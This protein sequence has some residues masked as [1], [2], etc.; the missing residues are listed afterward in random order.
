MRRYIFIIVLV[1]GCF[2]MQAQEKYSVVLEKSKQM[3]PY[4]SM[5]LLMDYQAWHP[6][7]A[8]VYYQLGNVCYGLV[9][10]RDPL[11]HYAELHTLLYQ[12]R[13]FYG[14]CLHFGKDQ[15][16]QGWQY[17]EIAKGEKKIEY[18]DLRRYIKPRMDDVK[19]RQIAC[20]SIHSSFNRMVER[21]NHCQALFSSF[22]R[23]YTREKTAHWQLQPEERKM[24]IELQQ[25]ADKLEQD[26]AAFRQAL[27][28]QKIEGYDPVFRKEEIVLYRLDGLTY[29][30]FLQNDI[31]LWDYSKWV[32][33][34]LYE[35]TYVY[36]RLFEDIQREYD[37]LTAQLQRYAE[38]K[39]IAGSIDES[40]MGR[41]AR[42]E[43]QTPRI[44]SIRSMQNLA[45][46]GAAEQLIAKAPAPKSLREMQP[47]LQIAA[48]NYSATLDSAQQ[49][50]ITRLVQMAQPLRIQQQPTYTH[51][52]S[53]D[54]IR[55]TPDDGETVLTLLPD[56]RGYR[57][58]VYSDAQT[59]VLGLN[60]DLEIE[61]IILKLPNEKP[62]VYA[63]LSSDKWALITDKNV[64]F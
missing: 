63:K 33:R 5:Y 41:C 47:L 37:Q 42:L 40:L 24:L 8:A 58:V 59:R 11:H 50:I 1:L 44:D 10:S 53:G 38:G 48:D 9:P 18:E 19:K 14:N 22:L 15:K 6:E 43:L 57:C 39:E 64:Y 28:L 4:E 56:D 7:V 62:A 61:R 31:A 46:H 23:R 45:Q 21:Y 51:P 20:D 29:T 26:I 32:Q 30:D 60:R 55:F 49:L 25:S 17:E 54:I 16:L 36:E 34:F 13:L 27:T 3:S 2:S 52:I 12:S 35:Q